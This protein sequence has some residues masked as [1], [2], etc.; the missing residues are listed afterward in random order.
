MIDQERV[1]QS[2][3]PSTRYIFH[4]LQSKLQKQTSGK[5]NSQENVFSRLESRQYVPMGGRIKLIIFYVFFL[6]EIKRGD[7]SMYKEFKQF[8]EVPLI[9]PMGNYFLR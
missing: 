4:P 2:L 1:Q 8:R 3:D 5:K 7:Y 6:L 9:T